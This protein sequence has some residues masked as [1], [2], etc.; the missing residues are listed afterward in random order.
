MGPEEEEEGA[1]SRMPSMEEECERGGEMCIFS[2]SSFE[3]WDAETWL[4]L[5]LFLLASDSVCCFLRR[6]ILVAER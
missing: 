4:P 1:L 2:F 6:R 5:I 3:S